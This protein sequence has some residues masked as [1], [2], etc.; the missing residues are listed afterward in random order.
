MWTG[1]ATDLGDARAERACLWRRRGLL[2]I[3]TKYDWKLRQRADLMLERGDLDGQALWRRI[4]RA[5]IEL[6]APAKGPPKSNYF[7]GTINPYHGM[8]LNEASF[9]KTR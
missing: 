9:N 5:I 7:S 6:Q 1:L 8:A 3:S 4:R 2:G